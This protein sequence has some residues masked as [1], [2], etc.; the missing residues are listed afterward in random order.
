MFHGKTYSLHYLWKRE[1]L[2]MHTVIL[3]ASVM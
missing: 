3:Q 1:G 2:K